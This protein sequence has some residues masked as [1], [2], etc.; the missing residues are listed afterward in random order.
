MAWDAAFVATATWAKPE[1][2]ETF[3]RN[4]DPQWIEAA[5]SATGTGTVRRRRLPVEEVVWVVL[6]MA[7]Y[8]DRPMED[9]VSK[10]ELAL[11]G[12]SGTVARSSVVQARQRLGSEA[13]KWLFERSAS[14]WAHA[15]ADGHRW[16]G[17][18]LYGMD[19]S[20]LRVPDTPE[21]RAHFGGQAGRKSSISGYP[22]VRLVALMVLR[23]H[24]LAG[25]WLGP[26]G[27]T[28][29]LGAAKELEGKVPSHS[30]TILDRGFFAAPLLVGIERAGNSRHWLTRAKSNNKWRV[31][32][33]LGKGDELVEMDVSAQARKQD[34]SLSRTWRMRA[35]RYRRPGFRAQ[36]LLTSL[37]DAKEYP[38]EEIVALYHERW[39]LELGYD[40]LKTELLDREETIRSKTRDGVEQELWGVLL[41][42]NLVRLE[43]ERVAKAAKIEPT[44]ISFVE[45]LRLIRDEW[46]WLSVTSP[47]AIPRRLATMRANMKRYILPPRRRRRSYPRAVKIKMSN[48]DRKRPRVENRRK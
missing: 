18:A 23:S 16:R 10:L 24:L 21:N 44:R 48:Y 5:L 13:M 33:R 6:G 46:L 31:V 17:L 22:M 47:G 27:G 19:G 2:L 34:P 12:G 43:M 8:R 7:L 1:Q 36:V 42:Y 3:R 41:A 28:G 39:E 40:E 32:E 29:E 30:L 9:I 35:I 11:P 37:L 38:A 14:A 15:S 4:L 26:Y 45:A 25:A 20:T